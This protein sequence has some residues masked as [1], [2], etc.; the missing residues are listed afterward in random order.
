MSRSRLLPISLV[1]LLALVVL[2][3]V[4]PRFTLPDGAG[5]DGDRDGERGTGPGHDPADW[6][7]AQRAD[8]DG[9]FPQERFEAALQ[10]AQVERAAAR[11]LSGA[12]RATSGGALV[13]QQAGP[14]NIGGRVTALAVASDGSIYLGS[15]NGGVWKSV[16]AGVNWTC[17]TDQ[18]PF[19]SVGAL[20]ADPSTPGTIY[21]GTGEANSSVDSYDG[22]GLWRTTDGGASWAN[23]GLTTT[24]RIARV[25]VDPTNPAHVLVAAMGRQFSTNP[26]RGLYQTLDGGASWSQVL[27]VSDSTGVTDLVV[28]PAHPDTMFCSTWERVRRLTYRRTSGPESG[29]WRS[30]DRGTTW[31]RMSTG[32]PTPTDSVGRIALAVAP[33][34]PS[35]VYAQV[36]G[37]YSLGYSGVGFY[38]STDGGTSWTRRSSGGSWSSNFGGFAWYF[39][40]IGVDPNNPDHVWSLGVS[41]FSSAN[42]GSTW[43]SVNGALH[44]DQHAIWIDPANSSHIY[45]GNDGGFWWSTTGTSWTHSS[46]LPISQFYDGDVSAANANAIYGGLQ[47][48]STVMTTTGPSAWSTIQGGDGFHVLVD[49]V[50]PNIVFDEYQ[51]CS[52]GSGFYRSINGGPS[53]AG[54]SG[55]VSSDRFGWD[56]PIAMNPLNHNVLLAGSQYVYRSTN[57]GLTWGHVSPSLAWPADSVSQLT[58]GCITT[59]SISPA[60]TTV[61]YAGTDDGRVWRTIN[62]GGSWTEITAGL[63]GRWVTRVTADP[64][65][66]QVVYVTLSGFTTDN[67]AALVYRSASQGAAW[68]N[69]S[70]NLPNFPGNDLVVDPADTQTLYLATDL[71]V[72]ITRNQGSTWYSLGQ[73]LP[74]QAV[75]D[76]TLHAASRQL[77]AFTHGRS[78]WKLDLTAMPAG[79]PAA[80]VTRLALSPAWPNPARGT[81]RMSIEIAQAASAEVAIYDVIGR[82]VST[83]HEGA[84]AA[85]R[86]DLAWDRRDARGARAAAGVYFVRAVVGGA[87]RTQRLVLVD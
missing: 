6:F 28:N 62:R 74:L 50:N 41:L 79:V 65:D 24:G 46:D 82:R 43:G 5:R 70:G 72:W 64:A 30:I 27:S 26:D 8:R 45:E 69:V 87:T 57:N 71:G 77:F 36:T 40:D 25:V 9:S 32:L 78:A 1:A 86:H 3:F 15:A 34:R 68:T 59:L 42:G 39:G 58:Y 54:T 19:Y 20:A 47:D 35:T 29:V 7:Y 56:T 73:G 38:R 49:P 13:W 37:G 23:L 85:G 21:C 22:N 44:A 51:N 52:S 16:N 76:L 61:Y 12:L 75:L 31:T 48:N 63:P 55:W 67:P 33:S 10:Q 2:A 80:A 17:V 60:D 84:L 18:Q 66:A 53:Q 11:G 14:F 81:V 4:V 83:L